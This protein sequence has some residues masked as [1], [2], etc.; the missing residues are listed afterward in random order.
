M[1]YIYFQ[2]VEKYLFIFNLLK[3]GVDNGILMDQSV[4]IIMCYLSLP[5]TRYIV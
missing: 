2:I 1:N 5:T 4:H 3:I